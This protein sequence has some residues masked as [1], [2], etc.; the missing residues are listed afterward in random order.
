MTSPPIPFA[1]QRMPALALAPGGAVRVDGDGVL[2]TLSREAAQK[3]LQQESHLLCHAAFVLRRLGA[4]RS[5]SLHLDLAEL[6]AFVLPARIFIPTAIG[7]AR[8]LGLSPP[9][10]REDEP[11]FLMMAAQHLLQRLDPKADDAPRAARIAAAMGR[12]GWRFAPFVLARLAHP[13]PQPGGFDVWE[14]LPEIEEH[15]PRGHPA[16][17][18]VSI[19]ETRRHLFAALGEG[20]E[21]RPQQADYAGT[22]SRIFAPPVSEGDP[23]VIIAEAGT[24][25][26][27]TLG[28]AAPA[29]L[30]AEKSDATVT[31]STYTRNLQR[32][33]DQEMSRIWPDPAEKR[34]KV[35]IRKGRENYLCLLNYQEAQ[36]RIA[37]APGAD[38]VMLGLVA[39]WITS[40]RD[41]DLLGGDFPSFLLA[42]SPFIR[43]LTD[44]RGECI[45]SACQH[46]RRCFVETSADRATRARI[47]IANHALVMV[48][49]ALASQSL[50]DAEV[51]TGEAGA[52]PGMGHFI[53][54][55]GHH[56]FDAA[57]SAFALHLTGLEGA[58]LRRWIRG[59]EG[60]GASRM[61]GLSE[62][63]DDLVR[64]D[65]DL[66]KKLESA[67]EA[68]AILPGP[69]WGQRVTGG[70]PRGP[71]ERFLLSLRAQVFLRSPDSDSDYDIE[72]EPHPLAEGVGDAALA[73]AKALR[74]L[75][76]PLLAL[77]AG[78]KGKLDAEAEELETHEK[79]RLTAVAR[80]IARR[81]RIILPGWIA[82][83]DRLGKG[84][85]TPDDVFVDWFG[86]SRS[87][88]RETDMGYFRHYL[89]P[90][91][92]F[93]AEV[94]TRAQGALIT[95]ATLRDRLPEAEIADASAEL[96]WRAA[97]IRTGAVHLPVA[98][99]RHGFASPFN[100]P[101]TTR[102]IVINDVPQNN[103]DARA[104]AYAALIRA[105]GG[106]ALGLFTA[107]RT[108]RAV[109][110]R[111]LPLLEA[112]DLTLFAQHADA[113]DTGT[114][115]DLFRA[116]EDSSLLGTDALR[117]GVDVP[118]R[119]LRMV[120]FD[121][122]PWPRPDICHKARRKAFGGRGYDEMMTRLRLRQAYGRL[123]RAE[124][125]RGVF[126]VLEA[127]TPTRL[128]SGLPDGVIPAR[129]GLA[130]AV[131][132]IRG[133]LANPAIEAEALAT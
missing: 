103:P 41:G 74:A 124:G 88:G 70:A 58:E 77:E 129:V 19:E 24:G 97:E 131:R 85:G 89:D 11:A 93:A 51:K 5:R 1:A 107:I 69:G 117:D 61:R 26:G 111:L 59:R 100:Y 120:L 30:Y 23:H 68:A 83:L 53:F 52:P 49:A 123:I 3:A 36:S 101:A 28:Y 46:Y 10:T 22:V 12:A 48:R 64:D 118:G 110:K 45:Y 130:E 60:D 90:T 116:D 82:M 4:E 8:L 33:I 7:M 20:R 96:D 35:V 112:D 109:H 98:A 81:S 76:S 38:S 106:G 105:S 99:E 125:D 133:F 25:I 108:L 122:V 84:D 6:A 126:C 78:L 43:A 56:L 128:L 57:D 65:E 75:Q 102:V 14:K 71:F 21:Q 86:V 72:C 79:A 67:I 92:P 17:V 13:A 73:L 29:T 2:A 114:L 44:R 9:A 91:K 66:K 39:R 115:V 113:I 34:E 31:I 42:Q 87:D 95:S 50:D 47:V 62:R 15:P 80:G 54:D 119:S 132:L 94:L 63:A 55:E 18:S 32:Q 121:R 37:L 27:K 16:T 40:T 127:R 104:A